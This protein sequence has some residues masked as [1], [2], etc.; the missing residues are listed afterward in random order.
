MKVHDPIGIASAPRET[1]QA[2]QEHLDAV[3][4]P[5]DNPRLVLVTDRQGDR[6]NAAYAALIKLGHGENETALLS[7][8][9][10]GPRFG[11]LGVEALAELV[12]WAESQQFNIKETVLS[13]GDF[14]RV[15]AEPDEHEVKA[16][17]AAC[18]FTD[19]A[20]YTTPQPRVEQDW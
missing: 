15:L 20:I 10:F 7:A 6:Q 12:R 11:E 2:L 8:P 14:Q 9:S 5:H 19:P 4:A 13:A 17:F 1:W 16:L 18:N 3:T